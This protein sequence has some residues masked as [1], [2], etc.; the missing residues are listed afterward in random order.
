MF[1]EGFNAFDMEE[2]RQFNTTESSDML[3]G[4]SQREVSKSNRANSY[5]HTTSTEVGSKH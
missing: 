3:S 5:Q 4:V 2:D 1:H